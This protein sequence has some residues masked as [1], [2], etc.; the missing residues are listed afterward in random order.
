[1]ET[2]RNDN[3]AIPEA[4]RNDFYTSMVEHSLKD[5]DEGTKS[6]FDVS[7]ALRE[8]LIDPDK[9]LPKPQVVISQ[10]KD[11]E[12][13]MMGT[14]GNFSVIIGKAKSKKSFFIGTL[15]AAILSNEVKLGHLKGYLPPDKR[16]VL[17]FDTEQGE[18]SVQL[19]L[20]RILRQA[21][22]NDRHSID[23]RF[24]RKYTPAERLQI[25]ETAIHQTPN[26]GFVVIDGIRDLITS[27]NDEEQATNIT[28]K[29]LKWTEELNIHIVTVLHQNKGDTNARGHVG[30]ELINKAELVLSVT[31]DS[32]TGEISV[33]SAEQVRWKEP[34][35]FA[36]EIDMDGLPCAAHDYELRTETK[37][38]QFD[39]LDME[40]YKMYELLQMVFRTQPEY[41]YSEL[42]TALIVASKNKFKHKLGMNRAKE[43]ITYCKNKE[44]LVQNGRKQPYKLGEYEIL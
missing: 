43:L 9:E 30:T 42:V 40:D 32:Q 23:I 18:W 13:I 28:S 33:V 20:K 25:I 29:L 16:R 1:M 8:S 12:S 7:T 31:K 17:Y 24:L 34:K 15:T 39:I 2:T 19:A 38:N 11:G 14:L 27:I 41:S 36:F 4:E 35:D 22:Y 44:F 21:N 3:K 5:L 26:I 10:E 37:K 6:D